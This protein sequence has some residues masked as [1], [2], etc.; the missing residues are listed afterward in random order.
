MF[1]GGIIMGE[2]INLKPIWKST[3]PEELLVYHASSLEDE[4]RFYLNQT[5]YIV[6]KDNKD[7]ICSVIF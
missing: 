3:N 6:A 2:R 5:Q 7:G 1:Y 4:I